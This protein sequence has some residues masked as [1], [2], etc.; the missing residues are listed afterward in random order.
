MPRKKV[1]LAY[2]GGLDTSVI[3]HW[4]AS[5]GYEVICC[6]VDVGQGDLFGLKEKALA[7]GAYDF[8][9]RDA[10][11]EFIKSGLFQC[12]RVQAR[13][14]GEYLLGTAIARPFIAKKVI[15]VAKERGAVAVAHGATGKGNDQVR[16][17]LAVCSIDDSLMV[18]APWRDKQFRKAIPGRKE[19]IEYASKNNIPISNTQSK[20]WSTDKNI[21]HTSHEAGRLEDPWQSPPDDIFEMSYCP[22]IKEEYLDISLIFKDGEVSG[23]RSQNNKDSVEIIISFE[24]GF[25]VCVNYFGNDDLTIIKTLN[26]CAGARGI[27][28]I[29]TVE[30]RIVGMKAR[31]V[32]EAPGMTLLYAAHLALLK[33]CL[34]K[35]DLHHLLHASIDYGRLVYEGRWFSDEK[36]SM[37]SIIDT[38]NKKVTGDV[39]LLLHKGGF[40]IAG[41]RSPYSLYSEGL[42]TMEGGEEFF[43]QDDASGFLKISGIE[44]KIQAKRRRMIYGR[45]E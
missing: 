10:K 44:A 25:P 28:V 13:Y 37:D 20:P 16:F 8:V 18:I 4:L 38:W 30:D 21:G 41:R 14:E 3:C 26:A 15:D 12:L 19:A 31:G 17:E 5:R 40:R 6:V 11:Y 35:E 27:G 9:L 32:Y 2:S 22:W 45:A 36:E 23:V 7:S 34:S 33:L 24:D 39:R 29:D 1:V 42:A 43:N